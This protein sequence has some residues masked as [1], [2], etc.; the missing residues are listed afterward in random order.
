MHRCMLSLA[1][2]SSRWSRSHSTLAENASGDPR[3]FGWQVVVGIEAHA[4]IKSRKKLFSDSWTNDPPQP[5]STRVSAFDASFPGTLPRLNSTCVAL[6]V[7]TALALN[8][9]VQR[10]STFDRKHYFY[11]DLPAGYQITQHYAPIS[12]GGYLMLANCMRKVGIKQIQLE[13]DTGKSTFDVHL[14]KSSIDLNRAGTALLE[15]VS[16]PDMSSPEEAG[17]YVRTLQ[18]VLRSVAASDGNMEQGS[19][20]CD[21]NVSIN[22]KGEPAGTR[23]EI[24]NLNSVKNMQVAIAS[25]VFRHIEILTS[26]QEVKQETRGFDEEKAET[27]SL[28]SKE[29][30]PDYRYMPDPNIPPLLLTE[31]YIDKIRSSMPELPDATRE[32]LLAQGLSAQ[33]T[34]VLMTADAGREVGMDGTFGQGGVVAYFDAVSEGRD[35]KIVV[36]W[37]VQVLFGQL[38]ARSQTFT[39]NQIMAAQLGSLIDMVQSGVI[40]GSSGK[41]ILRLMLDNP[42]SKTPEELAKEHSL[43]ALD[44]GDSSMEAWCREVIGSNPEVADAIR[45][46]NVNVVNKLVGRVMKKS[47]G[48]ADA[49]S[50]RK[51]LLEIIAAKGA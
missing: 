27:F 17:E 24:K 30:A 32:R 28:R 11:K 48:T 9:N 26:G 31:S 40:T 8:S 21:V 51:L 19:L 7:R 36:N 6:G 44:K 13:Q 50:V 42:S 2:Q 14:G 3:W 10:R 37:I 20:R 35:P 1:R 41:L 33:D 43:I 5:P 16:D 29:D 4:Q 22:K 34:G 49:L 12:L 23:C 18:A 38:A 15:I 45:A 47:R 25:E 46:G 39:E